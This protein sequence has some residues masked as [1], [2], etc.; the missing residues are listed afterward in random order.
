[1][2]RLDQLKEEIGWL[3][4]AFGLLM[5]TNL[6]LIAWLIQH[7]QTQ[8]RLITALN[9]IAIVVVTVIIYLINKQAY[10]KIDEIGEL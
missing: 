6:S 7:Y 3:K 10:K 9:A 5:A 2:A 8:S 4:V 1:M